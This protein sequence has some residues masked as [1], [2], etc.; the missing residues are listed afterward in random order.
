MRN[1]TGSAIA[2]GKAQV[3][4]TPPGLSA[5]YS[6]G[7]PFQL[8]FG[9]LNIFEGIIHRNNFTRLPRLGSENQDTNW[10]LV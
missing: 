5:G 7:Q 4:V 6:T 1:Q 10:V 3:Q 8:G 9:Y 2:M